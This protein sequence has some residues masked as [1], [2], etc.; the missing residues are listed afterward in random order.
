[1]GPE[2]PKAKGPLVQPINALESSGFETDTRIIG[3]SS[4]CAGSMPMED[5]GVPG[6]KIDKE[7]GR[8]SSVVDPNTVK[9]VFSA[10]MASDDVEMHGEAH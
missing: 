2:D 1:M 5:S 9:A 6:A 8:S 4:S 3:E 10:A 7:I